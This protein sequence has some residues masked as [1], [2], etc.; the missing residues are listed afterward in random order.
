MTATPLW[1]SMLFV[2]VTVERFVAGAAKRGADA[3]ILDLEDSIP[4]AEKERA[5]NLIV[6]A[7]TTVSAAGA[8]V[9]VRVNRPWRLLVRDLEAAIGPGV[10][11]LM[12]P[13][14][15]SADHLRLIA[16][17]VDEIEA[18]RGVPHGHTRLIAMLETPG[19]I[20]RAETIAA[21]HPRL[22][23]ITVGAEDL[24]LSVGMAPEAEALFVPKQLAVFAARAAGIQPL[25][26]LGT[27]ADFAD[28]DSFRQT[29]RRSRKL[30]FTG[31][32]V[33]HPS[34]VAILNEEFSPQPDEVDRARRMVAAY[35]EAT[36]TGKG[37][38]AFD[39]KMIDI[40]VVRRAQT[41][42]DHHHAITSR[43]GT[44]AG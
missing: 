21:A 22:T 1:R 11:A 36:K 13:K 35:D 9:I 27:V 39:G 31:A 33:I 30:G 20:F 24:A 19:S 12:L 23:G 15:E 34:Q 29:I 5:R 3:I 38:I 17:T 16:E 18:E 4:P 8:D 10:G 44:K 28:L 40:P 37:A 6:A 32:S 2:P 7:A 25:G 41:L 42:L 43:I 26:F 14:I